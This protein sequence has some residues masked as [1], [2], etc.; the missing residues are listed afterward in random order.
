VRVIL[1]R[2]DRFVLWTFVLPALLI[3]LFAQ[4]YPLAYSLVVSV[5]H[6]ALADSDV[7]QGFVGL[8]NYLQVLQDP[9]FQYACTISFV[10]MVVATTVEIVLGFVVGYVTVG[11]TIPLKVARTLLIVPMIIAPVTVGIMWRMFLDGKYGLLNHILG[12]V[13]IPG[14]NWLGDPRFAL[15]G[16]ILLDIWEWTPFAMIIYVAAIGS[17][18]ESVVEAAR[19]DGASSLH[20][21]RR[22][23]WPL[24]WPAT[25][26]ILIFRMIDTFFVFD[27]IYTLTYGGPGTS[28]QV[29]SLYIYRQGLS[30]FNISQ[31]AAASSLVMIVSLAIAVLLLTIQRRAQRAVY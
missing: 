23:I 17:I 14:P 25:I 27:Q 22:V 8:G 1:A 15:W 2:R 12:V 30:Y 11:Q 10:Y 18:S 19:I 13:G 24:V 26:L 31:A 5:M 16:T 9:A 3:I 6:W 21:I 28:T 29:V 20:I 4:G 7:P